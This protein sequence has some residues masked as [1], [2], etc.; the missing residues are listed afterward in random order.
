[1]PPPAPSREE[2]G[3][4]AETG[5]ILD[6]VKY[7]KWL[8][9]QQLAKQQESPAEGETI[10]ETFR[11]AQRDVEGWIDADANKPLVAQGAIA[12]IRGH[13]EVQRI[14]LSYQPHGAELVQKLWKHLEFMVENRRKYYAAT[15]GR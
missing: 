15:G 1:V 9:D 2:I 13:A 11:R 6:P 4:D 12:V 10:Y 3:Y 5:Q 8:R 14:I 7:R